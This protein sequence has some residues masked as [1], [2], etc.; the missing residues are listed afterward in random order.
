MIAKVCRILFA[1]ILLVDSADAAESSGAE[2]LI[3]PEKVTIGMSLAALKAVRPKSFDGPEAYKPADTKQRKWLTMMEII[4]LGQ[5]SQI[6]FWYLFSNDKLTGFLRTRNLVLVPPD[7]RVAEASS[8]YDSFTGLLGEPRQESLMRK[9]DSSFVP[10]QADVWT[11]DVT[12]LSFYFIATTK[13]ITTAVVA[14]SD[15]PI[16]QV[17]IR[18]DPKRFKVAENTDQSV[19]DLPRTR[20]RTAVD[21]EKSR[22]EPALP[23]P[24]LPQPNQVKQTPSVNK[25]KAEQTNK[26]YPSFELLSLVIAIALGAMWMGWRATSKSRRNS[27]K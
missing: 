8:A 4:D 9:G 22:K 17:F 7:G 1:V 14:P 2:A 26:T 20:Q 6:S 18:P 15:F 12:H 25:T 3:A 16:E 5:P 27:T 10:V 23:F 13:E 11:D 24:S 21:A 19:V